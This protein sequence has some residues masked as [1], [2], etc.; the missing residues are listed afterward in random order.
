MVTQTFADDQELVI[1]ARVAGLAAAA[2]AL[3]LRG[4]LVVTMVSAAARDG[5]VRGSD[6]AVRGGQASGHC[7]A[8]RT[9]VSDATRTFRSGKSRR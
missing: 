5:L 4:S 1:D 9:A 2:A 7:A 6:L 8:I 3:A